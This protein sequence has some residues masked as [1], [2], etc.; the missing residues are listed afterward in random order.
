[1]F[2]F[3]DNITLLL[4]QQNIEPFYLIQL[5]SPQNTF[6]DTN[7]NFPITISGIGTFLPDAGLLT[8]DS[9]KFS[10]VS[11]DREAYKIGYLDPT[12][13]KKAL[14]ESG[15]TGSKLIVRVGLFNTTGSVLDGIPP[16]MPMTD[17]NDLII[18]YSGTVDVQ[19]YTIDPENGSIIVGL[20]CT[21]P[22]STL[23]MTKSFYTSKE[24]LKTINI[25]DTA[26]DFINED[27]KKYILLWGK[28]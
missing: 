27:S 18:A 4:T 15:I 19:G 13:E 28:A 25:K 7:T 14:F 20:E 10:S 21:S 24:N 16:G 6:Y 8:I 9:P 11:V 26:F 3:S 23:D 1:M 22:M 5:I 12:G 2:K 17:I